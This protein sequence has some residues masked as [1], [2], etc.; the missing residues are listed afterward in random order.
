MTI[1]Y[2]DTIDAFKS[3]ARRMSYEQELSVDLS[4]ELKI[5]SALTSVQMLDDVTNVSKKA[6]FVYEMLQNIGVTIKHKDTTVCSFVVNEGMTFEDVECFKTHPA[7]YRF[8]LD[9]VFGVFLK[10][11]YPLLSESQEAE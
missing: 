11:S 2:R 8:F 5:P 4:S 10:N 7:I 3:Y 6:L 9:S 1:S